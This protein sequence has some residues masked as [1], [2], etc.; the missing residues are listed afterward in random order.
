MRTVS[1]SESEHDK[2][3]ESKRAEPLVQ[4]LERIELPTN[5]HIRVTPLPENRVCSR[6]CSIDAS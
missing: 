1:N 6:P 2:A 4:E 5:I 3:L